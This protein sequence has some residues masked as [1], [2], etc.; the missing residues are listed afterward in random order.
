MPQL[1]ERI[2]GEGVVLRR[3]R[4]SDAQALHQAILESTDH[5]RPW[6]SWIEQ[7]PQTAEQRRELLAGWE[8]DWATGGD[9]LYGVFIGDTV[10]GSCG[11]HRRLGPHA[12]EIGYWIHASFVRRGLA[13]EVAAL[14]TDAA[15]ALPEI[16]RVEIHHDRAN[17]ASAGVPR[18]VGYRLVGEQYDEAT[19][20]ADSGVECIWRM[21][22]REWN[23]HRNSAAAQRP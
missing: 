22:R 12:L 16:Q 9:A 23:A 1:P 18:R 10:A 14:L 8:D 4:V 17:V 7:E 20:P 13:S 11:L 6:M 5:L 21:E 2:E 15:L 19:A 3:W